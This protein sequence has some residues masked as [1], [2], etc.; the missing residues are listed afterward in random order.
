[1]NQNQPILV[2]LCYAR[3]GGTLFSRTLSCLPKVLLVSEVNPMLNAQGNIKEQ[4]KNWFGMD[5]QNESF[6]ESAKEV[7]EQCQGIVLSFVIRDFSFIDFTPHELNNFAPINSFSTLDALKVVLPVKPIAFVRN[8]FD[9]WISRGC[10]PHFSKGYL[11]YVNALLELDAPIYR[12]EDFCED[13]QRIIQAVCEKT[14]LPYSKL[15]FNNLSENKKITGDVD[16][17]NPS[18]G[19]RQDS[20]VHLKRKRLP[21]FLIKK[22]LSDPFL[23][24]ANALLEYSTDFYDA[25]FESEQSLLKLEIR[26]FLKR[27]L[28]KY[29]KDIF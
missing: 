16:L 15:L 19:N 21:Q 27:V 2:L 29:P 24:E 28:L 12:Y 3:S 14:G 23:S 1:M 5:V 9:V 18:R 7:Y 22:A 11:N 20:I 4:V 6:V 8:A 17:K 26:W 25:E 13:P 10:P